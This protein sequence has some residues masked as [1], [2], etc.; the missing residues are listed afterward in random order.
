VGVPTL[1]QLAEE[2][3]AKFGDYERLH[4]EGRTYTSFELSD[5]SRRLATG[6]LELGLQSGERVLVMIPNGPEA[7]TI[8]WATWRA[9][10]VVMPVLFL[11]QPHEVAKI[12]RD[13]EPALAITSPE[14]LPVVREAVDGVPSVRRIVTTGQ[15]VDGTVAFDDLLRRGRWTRRTWPPCCSQAGRPARRRA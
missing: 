11:L 7:G 14:F 2:H 3:D 15:A 9:G 6:L 8:Y 10:A 1:T 12:V 4:F 13:G 5:M